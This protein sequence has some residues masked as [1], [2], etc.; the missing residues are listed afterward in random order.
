[1]YQ[2]Q[3]WHVGLKFNAESH[4]ERIF[5]KLQFF[6]YEQ[7]LGLSGVVFRSLETKFS[8][9]FFPS[10]I[11]G[12]ERTQNASATETTRPHIFIITKSSKK[13]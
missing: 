5:S 13:I 7:T 9:S 12:L 2:A 3:I 11:D 1:M 6:R 10:A 8:W 4:E